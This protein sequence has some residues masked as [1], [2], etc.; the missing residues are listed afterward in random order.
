MWEREIVNNFLCFACF[1]NQHSPTWSSLLSKLC[2]F[3]ILHIYPLNHIWT[4]IRWN[5]RNSSKPNPDN[6]CSQENVSLLSR[7][8]QWLYP[9]IYNKVFRKEIYYEPFLC[10]QSIFYSRLKTLTKFSQVMVVWI[11]NKQLNFYFYS[12]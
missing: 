11:I 4:M 2:I 3:F 12:T 10:T 6:S 1:L 9:I 7:D 8:I 5:K